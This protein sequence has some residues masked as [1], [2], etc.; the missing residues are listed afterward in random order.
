MLI[1]EFARKTGL[2]TDTVRF[3]V[4]KGLLTPTTNGKG[5]RNPYQ[6]FTA[7][8]VRAAKFIRTAQFLGLSLKELAVI[9]EERRRGRITPGRQINILGAQLA[10]LEAKADEMETM[11]RYLRAKID[12]IAGGALG[13]PPDIEKYAQPRPKVQSRRLRW[14]T[15]A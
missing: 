8:H 1:S 14:S 11:R 4:R 5:G 9:G 7:E 2:T 10:E 3:Y 13:T 15:P 12:W 6:V